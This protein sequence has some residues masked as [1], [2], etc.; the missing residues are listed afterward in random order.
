MPKACFQNIMPS[1]FRASSLIRKVVRAAAPQT[2]FWSIASA[3]SGRPR[4]SPHSVQRLSK[5]PASKHRATEYCDGA[6]CWSFSCS[7]KP[8]SSRI[9]EESTPCSLSIKTHSRGLV[10][11]THPSPR[12]DAGMCGAMDP[13]DKPEEV[14]IGAGYFTNER[15]Q[16]FGR[17]RQIAISISSRRQTTIEFIS[18]AMT[19]EIDVAVAAPIKP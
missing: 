16:N 4:A 5:E 11:R 18:A 15:L 12:S 8:P 17:L 10:P 3:R 1:R 19:S 9:T 6:W 13:R 14:V 2:G 7:M